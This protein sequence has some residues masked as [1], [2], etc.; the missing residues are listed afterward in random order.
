MNPLFRKFQ[1]IAAK[2]NLANNTKRTK[3]HFARQVARE[4]DIHNIDRLTRGLEVPRRILPGMMLVY[5]YLAKGAGTLPHWDRH[6]LVFV[7]EVHDDGWTG[8]NLHYLHPM[9]R[10]KLFY[11]M[12]SKK[13][14]FGQNKLT[15]AATKKYLASKVVGRVKEIPNGLWEVASQMPFENF[16]KSNKYSVWQDTNRKKK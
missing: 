16:Q 14:H 8:V 2:S 11:D 12:D 6:P 13:V 5:E 10:A 1:T 3:E 4:D 7:L 15:R 9:L